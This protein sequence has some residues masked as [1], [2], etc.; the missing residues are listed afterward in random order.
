MRGYPMG[1]HSCSIDRRRRLN[2]TDQRIFNACTCSRAA[3]AHPERT[4]SKGVGKVSPSEAE[5]AA[6]SPEIAACR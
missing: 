5:A 2:A 3:A 1:L 6:Q 4:G